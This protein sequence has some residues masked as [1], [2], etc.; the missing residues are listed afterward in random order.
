MVCWGGVEIV[1]MSRFVVKYSFVCFL[2]DVRKLMND[3]KTTEVMEIMDHHGEELV[4]MRTSGGA[5]LLM[6]AAWYDSERCGIKMFEM[7]AD[8]HAANADGRNVLH[9]ASQNGSNRM[10]VWLLQRQADPLKKDNYGDNSID[11]AKSQQK[12]ETVEI[13]LQ[14]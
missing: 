4:K 7:G 12:H 8:V 6:E 11:G 3:G 10:V 2:V 13:L 14:Q 9:W 1:F 5:T